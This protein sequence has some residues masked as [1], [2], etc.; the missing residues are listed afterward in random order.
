MKAWALRGL[1]L[2]KNPFWK[3]FPSYSYD[4][5][6]KAPIVVLLFAWHSASENVEEP[7]SRYIT[8]GPSST[9]KLNY[10]KPG[11]CLPFVHV[12][13]LPQVI[14]KE[15]WP[16]LAC[17]QLW[18]PLCSYLC[19]NNRKNSELWYIRVVPKSITQEI[20]SLKIGFFFWKM[21]RTKKKCKIPPRP[22]C[23]S[24]EHSSH[25]SRMV[26]CKTKQ[27]RTNKQKQK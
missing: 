18:Q 2:V 9:C 4:Q 20:T 16:L 27:S 14:K 5:K 19:A 24:V 8:V 3:L 10:C 26:I 17:N 11:W 15:I 12:L 21:K 1:R 7:W 13:C 23:R 25:F 22:S 6:N